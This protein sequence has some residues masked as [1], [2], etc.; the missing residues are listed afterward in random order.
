MNNLRRNVRT[1][2]FRELFDRLPE[3]IQR[4]GVLTFREFVRNP[5]ARHCAGTD[6]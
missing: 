2:S 5:Q 6:R 1:G 3:H 4:L